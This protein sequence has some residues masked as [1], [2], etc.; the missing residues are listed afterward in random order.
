MA[1]SPAQLAAAPASHAAPPKTGDFPSL[2]DGDAKPQGNALPKKG[3]GK[4]SGVKAKV[5]AILLTV[6]RT[7]EVL[8][9]WTAK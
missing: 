4:L 2:T 9:L 8:G 6:G 5:E 1:L 3:G 7:G